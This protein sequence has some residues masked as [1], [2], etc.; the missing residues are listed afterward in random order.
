MLPGLGRN[1]QTCCEHFS[2]SKSLLLA[3]PRSRLSDMLSRQSMQ[4]YSA[5]MFSRA[6]A[7][8]KFIMLMRQ[9]L[10]ISDWSFSYSDLSQSQCIFQVRT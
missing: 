1:I 6:L 5:D 3:M 2:L 7:T 9:L 10:S 4:L 8:I